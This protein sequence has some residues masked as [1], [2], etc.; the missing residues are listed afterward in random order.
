MHVFKNPL[1]NDVA[2]TVLAVP[3][4]GLP[5]NKTQTERIPW[6]ASHASATSPLDLEKPHLAKA[7][8]DSLMEERLEQA[9]DLLG[10]PLDDVW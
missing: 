3:P 6:Q 9:D 10:N 4:G 2:S 7:R 8:L 1:V 5:A